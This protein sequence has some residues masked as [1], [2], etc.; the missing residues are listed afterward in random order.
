MMFIWILFLVIVAFIIWHFGSRS[1]KGMPWGEKKEDALDILK[2]RFAE[3]KIDEED[4]DER[5]AVL[6]DEF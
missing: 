5:K 4:Y 2:K 6:E 1:T 3:G